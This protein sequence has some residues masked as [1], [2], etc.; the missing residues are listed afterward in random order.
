[1]KPANHSF[2]ASKHPEIG[3]KTLHDRGIS[4][5]LY[6]PK[7]DER[8]SPMF[9]NV[10]QCPPMSANTISECCIFAPS[11]DTSHQT[12]RKK[13]CQYSSSSLQQASSS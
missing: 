5:T 10:R 4:R 13:L 7:L 2:G 11:N 1:M 12:F 8:C 6:H 3:I 9:A